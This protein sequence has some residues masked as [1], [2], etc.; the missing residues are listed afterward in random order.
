MPKKPYEPPS[1]FI[2]NVVL[3]AL[4]FANAL[5]KSKQDEVKQLKEA[6]AMA[7]SDLV[8]AQTQNIKLHE[9]ISNLKEGLNIIDP[10][11]VLRSECV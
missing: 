5:A 1:E 4:N 6:L 7:N 9:E 10:H 11:G 3:D 8:K 2:F